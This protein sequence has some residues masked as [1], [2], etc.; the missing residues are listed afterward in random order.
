[1]ENEKKVYVLTSGAYSDYRIQAIFS[2]ME[3][4]KE[5]MH[6]FNGD[7]ESDIEEFELDPKIDGINIHE[8]F[9]IGLNTWTIGMLYD[10]NVVFCRERNRTIADF[11][12]KNIWWSTRKL[13]K[14]ESIYMEK[15]MCISVIARSREHAIKIANEKRA[16][17][18]A[19]NEWPK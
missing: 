18:I 5:A 13:E 15:L 12:E 14:P 1:M 16:I 3:N 19:N 2:T 17:I 9:A 10:G 6:L 7:E 8:M 11:K 4:A